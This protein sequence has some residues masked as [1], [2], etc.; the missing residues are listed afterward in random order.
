[1]IPED[2]RDYSKCFPFQYAYEG[3]GSDCKSLDQ[4]TV[5]NL[6]DNLDFLHDLGPQFNTLGGICQQ[7]MMRKNHQ[8]EDFEYK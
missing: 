1:M 8:F 2:Q 3:I 7:S 4:L 5:S 6:G